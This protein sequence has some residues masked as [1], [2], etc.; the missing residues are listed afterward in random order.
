MNGDDIM[1]LNRRTALLG[2]ASIL[3]STQLL[4]QSAAVQSVKFTPAA[5]DA[6]QAANKSIFIE[7]TAPWCPTCK[8]Q[9]AVLTPL[10]AK[11][12][13]KNIVFFDI[14][15]DSQKN[16]LARFKVTQQSTLIAMRGNQEVSRSV[17]ETKAE[18]IEALLKSTI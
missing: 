16:I 13:Y 12:D 17:G 11:A 5:F 3:P 14:D 1:I 9:K 7:V 8:A 15:F 2:L 18:A 4:A 10:K 6:A